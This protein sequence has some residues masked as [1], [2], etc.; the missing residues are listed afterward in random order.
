MKRGGWEARRAQWEQARERLLKTR[1]GRRRVK[2][3]TEG[4]TTEKPEKN[5]ATEPMDREYA[6]LRGERVLHRTTTPMSVAHIRFGGKKQV[7]FMLPEVE[8]LKKLPD[9][10]LELDSWR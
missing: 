10:N 1:A 7:S 6:L 8:S 3:K 4:H 2:N 5:D 9:L